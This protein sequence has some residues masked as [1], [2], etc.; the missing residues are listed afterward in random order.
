MDLTHI[1]AHDQSTM[2]IKHPLTGEPLLDDNDDPMTITVYGAESLTYRKKMFDLRRKLVEDKATSFEDGEAFMLNMLIAVTS[3]WSIQ[4][5][6]K[7]PECKAAVVREVYTVQPWLKDQVDLFVHE[8]R[9]FL[10]VASA[11]SSK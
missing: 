6:G 1:E 10:S 9:N 11:A 4:I 8:K 2:D 5:D 7:K 3:D